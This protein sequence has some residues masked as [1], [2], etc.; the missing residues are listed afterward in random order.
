MQFKIFSIPIVGGER[1]NEEMNR[2]LRSKKVLHT[3]AQ[4]VQGEEG[5]FWC[6]CIKYI[7]NSLPNSGKKKKVDYRNVLSSESFTRFA[8]MRDVR[9]RLAKEEGIPAYAVFTDAELA[10][11][12][13]IEELTIAEMRKMK[14]IG[15]KKIEKFGH[16]FL[17]CHKDEKGK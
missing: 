12:A 4:L 14:G 2:F 7:E 17:N 1:A 9:K 5:I 16:C 6:F 3:E 8:R 13:K 11:L 15:V 10:E